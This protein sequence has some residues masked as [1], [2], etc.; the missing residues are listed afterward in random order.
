MQ[1][2]GFLQRGTFQVRCSSGQLPEAT[3]VIQIMLLVSL[4]LVVGTLASQEDSIFLFVFAKQKVFSSLSLLPREQGLNPLAQ[5]DASFVLIRQS[6]T[7]YSFV[8]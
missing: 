7:F 2:I 8:T 6:S 5:T 1:C 3:V 4:A